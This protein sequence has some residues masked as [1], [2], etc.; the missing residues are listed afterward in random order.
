MRRGQSP[1]GPVTAQASRPGAADTVQLVEL[2]VQPLRN[3]GR[4]ARIRRAGR[5]ADHRS[6]DNLRAGVGRTVQPGNFLAVGNVVR[7]GLHGVPVV[8]G[9]LE[10]VGLR[11]P[12]VVARLL[13]EVGQD[14]DDPT[15]VRA[16]PGVIA[17]CRERGADGRAAAAVLVGHVGEP[18]VTADRVLVGVV[19]QSEPQLL[20]VVAAGV[21]AG[22]FA[23]RLHRWEQQTDKR[24]DDGDH[25]Q[26]FDEREARGHSPAVG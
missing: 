8:V 22:S 23:G 24:A 16:P 21:A 17:R 12:G 20:E 13:F 26:E 7:G 18:V 4:P 5:G 25:D 6:V 10:T 1:V 15:D 19:V 2:L 9:T 11:D 14:L 3:A